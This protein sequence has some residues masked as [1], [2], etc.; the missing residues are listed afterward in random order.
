VNHEILLATLEFYGIN[1]VPGKLIKSYLTNRHQ[2][3]LINNNS[4]VGVSDWQKVEQSV[5]QGSIPGP[6][7]FLIY[8]NDL[9]YIINKTSKPILY[10]DDTSILCVN[11]NPSDLVTAIKGILGIINE[12]F[13]VCSLTLNLD[14]TNCVQF[15]PTPNIPKNIN[16]HYKD[17]QIHNTC[18]IKFLGLFIDSAL[19]W[20]E[21]ISQ[22]AIKMSSAGCAIRALSLIMRVF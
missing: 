11:S 1:G 21:H 2:R 8:I 4:S 3:T 14:K 20:K 13:S 15:S 16:I 12:W 9:P 19:S 22:R 5:P 17:T 6:L 10:A 18:N 7:I